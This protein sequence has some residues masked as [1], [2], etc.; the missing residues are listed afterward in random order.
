[1]SDTKSSK[2]INMSM[3][4]GYFMVKRGLKATKKSEKKKKNDK[5]NKKRHQLVNWKEFQNYH[6]RNIEENGNTRFTKDFRWVYE[7]YS[8]KNAFNN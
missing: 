8:Q 2:V 3:K 7:P 6:Q 5:S 1:M 4:S